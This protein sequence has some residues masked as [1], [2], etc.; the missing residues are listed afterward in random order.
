LGAI[1]TYLGHNYSDEKFLLDF[2]DMDAVKHIIQDE[3][4]DYILA[5][6]SEA[7]YI[8]AVTLSNELGIGCYDLLETA[9]LLH[10]KWAFKKF[11]LDNH[12]STPDAQYYTP[13]LNLTELSFPLAIKPTTLSG[14][15]GVDI[16]NS[17]SELEKAVI[18]SEKFSTDLILE[19]YVEGQLIADSLFLQD[20]KVIYGFVGDDKSYLNKYLINTAYPVTLK[21][22]VLDKMKH[23]VEKV[24]SYLQLVDGMFHLQIIIKDD[25]PYIIDVTRRIPG[26]LYPKLIEY[27]DGVAY[28]K[29]VVK[30]YLG[31]ALENEFERNSVLN[32][33][34]QKFVIRHCVM[35]A[36]NG[37]IKDVK[38]DHILREK[39]C[40]RLDLIEAG[41]AVKDFMVDVI[42]II[43]IEL[44]SRDDDMINNIN[45]L[46]SPVIEEES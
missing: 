25:I 11:C 12:I 30:S 34:Q 41:Q 40:Y 3:S 8:S 9:Q 10:N 44:D 36:S 7:A 37:T 26:D 38:V 24:A 45:S 15:Q 22:E 14:G 13:Q 17:V 46:I 27:C 21:Q 19:E 43:F 1:K 29:A 28:S 5:G 2:N 6:C 35:A 23:D 18:K 31:K 4:V 32:N 16:V 42:A 39:I 20:Q 33:K